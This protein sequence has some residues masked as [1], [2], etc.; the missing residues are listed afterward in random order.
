MGQKL[1]CS[2]PFQTIPYVT[3]YPDQQLH[4]R[5]QGMCLP[6]HIWH[7]SCKWN[8]HLIKFTI[9]H[10]HSPRSVSCTGQRTKWIW[11]RNH[12]LF[13]L[14]GLDSVTHLCSPSR[15]VVSLLVFYFPYIEA[16]TVASHCN[17]P[18]ST[19]QRAICGDSVS[20]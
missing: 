1:L 14:Q 15:N 13:I 20:S 5:Y 18:H 4:A 8:H 3:L 6:K 7:S 16:V 12:P 10:C 11:G 19:G 17:S 2:G 9:I